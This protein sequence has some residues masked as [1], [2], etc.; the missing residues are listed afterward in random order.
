MSLSSG[1][2]PA[3]D[4]AIREVGPDLGFRLLLR[5]LSQYWA[6]IDRSTYERYTAMGRKFGYGDQLVPVVD[7][8]VDLD[9]D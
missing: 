2:V 8:L 7:F 1:V 6:P 4:L 3:L 5:C 9:K